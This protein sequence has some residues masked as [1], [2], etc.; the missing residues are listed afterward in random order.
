MNQD[1]Q[2][3]VFQLDSHCYGVRLA[4]VERVIHAVESAPLPG[5]PDIVYG[6][7]NHRGQILP[8]INLRKRF[9]FPLRDVLVTDQF[10]ITATAKRAVA[11]AVDRV[12][13]MVT[14]PEHEVVAS[15]RIL[16]DAGQIEAAVQ[17][18]DDLVL[19]HD[20]EHVLS[21]DELRVLDDA[22]ARRSSDGE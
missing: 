18:G 19:V 15:E 20:L 9:G 5:A 10:V 7:I 3:L 8:V 6:V 22:L 16:D 14:R 17:I 11:L 12:Q 21:Q 13:G 4:L 2:L 1:V